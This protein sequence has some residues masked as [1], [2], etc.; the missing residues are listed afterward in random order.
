MASVIV[1]GSSEET[2]K[3]VSALKNSFDVVNKRAIVPTS[4]GGMTIVEV[5][6][7]RVGK[8]GYTQE[9]V[10]KGL[11]CCTNKEKSCSECPYRK[12]E[13]C[14]NKMHMDSALVVSRMLNSK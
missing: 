12:E 11:N 10:L 14:V 6:S 2:K 8:D 7:E 13:N 1:Q 5:F 4:D 9:E 3:V